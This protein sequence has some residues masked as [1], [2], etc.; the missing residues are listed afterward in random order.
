MFKFLFLTFALVSCAGVETINKGEPEKVQ[1]VQQKIVAQEYT[2]KPGEVVRI[3]FPI[4][5]FSKGAA[6][7]CDE[8]KIPFYEKENSYHAFYA[9]SYFSK[10]SPSVCRIIKG[11]ESIVVAN[12]KVTD[13]DF[14]SEKLNVDKRR[15]TLNPKDLK[16]VQTEQ[17]FLNKN[18]ASSPDHPF[19][20]E[21]FVLPI[22]NIVTSIY[23]SRRLFNKKKQTQHLGTDFRAAVGEP[24]VAANAGKIVVARDLFFTGYTVTIDHGLG[25]FSIYGHLSKLEAVEGEYVPRGAVIGLSGAT[26]RVTGPHLHW[27]VKINGHFIEGESLVRESSF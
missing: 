7:E 10:M 23:G 5:D 22:G 14:P 4:N 21:P 25:I 26:G 11:S 6:L 16:R 20:T 9:E 12:I 27:G 8:Q 2:V 3:N 18:Y 13:K 19:F 17:I 15:V 1:P 24:I